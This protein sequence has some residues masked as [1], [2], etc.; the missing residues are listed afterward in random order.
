MSQS[1]LDE[2]SFREDLPV[3]PC[4][5]L[6]VIDQ[7]RLHR[8]YRTL[9]LIDACVEELIRLYAW[10][11]VTVAD[12]HNIELAGDEWNQ[13]G[14]TKVVGTSFVLRDNELLMQQ[15]AGLQMFGFGGA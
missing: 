9:Q 10:L 7:L 1:P 8:K 12:M 6:L 14:F 2:G 4:N 15:I 3:R 11:D 5:T 13:I